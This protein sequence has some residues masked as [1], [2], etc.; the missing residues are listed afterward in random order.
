[1]TDLMTILVN[2]TIINA[3]PLNTNFDIIT[4]YDESATNSTAGSASGTGEFI[5]TNTTM[6]F[7]PGYS[8]KIIGIMPTFTT[9]TLTN[10]WVVLKVTNNTTGLTHYFGSDSESYVW[11]NDGSDHSK[12]YA[13]NTSGKMVFDVLNANTGN[14][15]SPS[16]QD[17]QTG[18]TNQLDIGTS[19]TLALY[20]QSSRFN[21][22]VTCNKS[23][24]KYSVLYQ[25]VPTMS[26]NNASGY[27]S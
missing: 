2:G 18:F 27:F 10:G 23:T 15:G 22:S 24:V 4:K 11:T 20:A 3:S 17:V 12:L 14:S 19:F 6:T 9:S 26:T 7:N 13:G 8:V 1:M 16:F 21:N 25:R 5:V